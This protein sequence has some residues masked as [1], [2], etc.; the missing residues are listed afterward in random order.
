[1]EPRIE[2]DSVALLLHPCEEAYFISLVWDGG[3]LRIKDSNVLREATLFTQ[4]GQAVLSPGILLFPL[5][6]NRYRKHN[7]D[8]A[9]TNV[10]LISSRKGSIIV[11]CVSKDAATLLYEKCQQGEIKIN[12][13]Y[14]IYPSYVHCQ[15]A[16]PLKQLEEE[17]ITEETE[18][19]N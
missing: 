13:C 16:S 11:N 14:S 10:C 19:T 15:D 18:G 8:Q 9:G 17:L 4:T 1:M 7:P 3:F 5:R 6:W 2:D 12:H